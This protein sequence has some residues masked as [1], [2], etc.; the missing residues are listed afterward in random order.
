[1]TTSPVRVVYDCVVFLQ[2]AGRRANAARKCLELVDDGTVE[3]CLSTDVLEE[4]EDVLHRPEILGRFPL[5]GSEESQ[6][7]L[8]TARRKALL[9]PNVPKVFTLPRDPDDEP[10]TD[11]A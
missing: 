1:M 9:L 10:Y 6:A 11:L 7:L 4:I 8:R 2:G 5:I 3:L